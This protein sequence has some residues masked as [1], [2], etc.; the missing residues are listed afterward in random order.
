MN[1][2]PFTYQRW[3]FKA[4]CLTLINILAIFSIYGLLELTR[5][6]YDDFWIS[7]LYV[8][9]IVVI[10]HFYFKLTKSSKFFVREGAY[11]IEDGIVFIETE[12]KT[13]SLNNVEGI[14]GT[15]I[16]FWG[17]NKSGMLKFDYNRKTLTLMSLEV[18]DIK[19]FSESGLYGLFETTR[20]NN[21][22]LKKEDTYDFCYEVKK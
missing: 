12:K 3:F 9:I 19:S 4:F 15:T 2:T 13:Y 8:A 7:W 20:E 1:K 14:F 18:E 5:I 10:T 11:W 17:Y 21:P 16:S 6:Q 22:E